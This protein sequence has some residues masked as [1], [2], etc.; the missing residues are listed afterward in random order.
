MYD[1]HAP[2]YVR[3]KAGKIALDLAKDDLTKRVI[4]EYIKSEHK[5]IQQ[6][7]EALRSKSLQKYSGQQI[8]TRVFVLGNSGSGKS[9]LVESLKRKGV[10]YY[11][12]VPE[13]DVLLHT[14]GIV[15]SIHQSQDAGRLLYYD[16][17]GDTEYFSSHAAILEM[18]SH[19]TV[20]NNAFLIVADLRKDGMTLCNEIGYWLSFI[21]YH[22]KA[23]DS[24]CQ[25]VVVLSHSDFLSLAECASTVESIR[26]YLHSTHMNQCDEV[27]LILLKSFH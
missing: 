23:L 27:T 17:A 21:S 4:R 22:A 18:V 6:E 9:T 15:P 25:V 12:S 24:Q 13:V 20:G 5:S 16:F 2:I 8:I 11:F 10:Y 7:Y 26:H 19:S 3:N 1:Y 14:A